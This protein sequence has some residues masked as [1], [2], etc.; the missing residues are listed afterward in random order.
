MGIYDHGNL[1]LKMILDNEFELLYIASYQKILQLPYVDKFLS[2]IQRKFRDAYI[3]R[4]QRKD[5][6]K[7]FDF[8][9]EYSLTLHGAEE[10][11]KVMQSMPV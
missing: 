10:E 9:A 4:L 11:N 3:T 6:Y 5:Y 7:S 8:G 2:D 1:S